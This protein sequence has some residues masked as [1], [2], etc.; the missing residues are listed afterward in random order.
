MDCILS[1]KFYLDKEHPLVEKLKL[2]CCVTNL[3]YAKNIA[4]GLPVGNMN[5]FDIL[6]EEG[7]V[8]TAFPRA[9]VNNYL[10]DP[11]INIIDKTIT[12]K[13][14]RIGNR[15]QLRPNQEKFC[16]NLLDAL[17]TTYGTSAQAGCGFGKTVCSLSMISKLSVPT[18]IIVHKTFLVNQ[19]LENIQKFLIVPD[20]DIGIISGD[21]V[22]WDENKTITIALVQSLLAKDLPKEFYESFG[23]LVL[24]EEHRFGAS[25]LN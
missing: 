21:T 22:E 25:C 5:R 3:A 14:C 17:L 4:Y 9:L 19:W 24:D 16:S 6:Y 23:F 12:G 1:G 18:I 13:P 10:K 7:D 15:I 20:K 11:S 8:Y 2:K